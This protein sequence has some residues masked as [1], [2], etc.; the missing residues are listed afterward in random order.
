MTLETAAPEVATRLERAVE[1]KQEKE[2]E[3]RPKAATPCSAFPFFSTIAEISEIFYRKFIS[4]KSSPLL[5]QKKKRNHD[6]KRARYHT[7]CP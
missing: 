6:H 7:G 1:R 5:W 3:A 4:P 2:E